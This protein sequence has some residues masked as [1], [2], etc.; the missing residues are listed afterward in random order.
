MNLSRIKKMSYKLLIGLLTLVILFHCFVI[1]KI[2]PYNIAWG[3]KLKNDS[4]MYFLETI[5]ILMNV[6]LIV[7]LLMKF[8]Y[9]THRFSNKLIIGILW[10]FQALFILNTVGNMFAKSNGEKYFAIITFFFVILIGI[11]LKKSDRSNSP[12]EELK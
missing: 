7:V 9:I 1:A 3:G 11:I 8:N 5:S 6:F 2:I 10:F 4:E 12:S